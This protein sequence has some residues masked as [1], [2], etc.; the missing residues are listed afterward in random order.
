MNI[1]EWKEKLKQNWECK[2]DELKQ[3][4]EKHGNE[5][6]LPHGVLRNWLGYQKLDYRNMI[7]GKRSQM[8]LLKVQRF[9]ALG[10]RIEESKRIVTYSWKKRKQQLQEYRTTHGHL[11]I[12]LSHELLGNY[13]HMQRWGYTQFMEGKSKCN[14][15]NDARIK[16]LT[17]MGFQ[18]NLEKRKGPQDR[19]KFKSWSERFQDLLEFRRTYG[20]TRVPYE[21]Q[22]DLMLADWV[23]NQRRDYKKMKDGNKT[24]MTPEK[25]LKLFD[26]DFVFNN[27]CGRGKTMDLDKT[28][29]TAANKK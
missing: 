13:I 14:G 27:T 8:T 29:E 15:I 9:A 11:K 19:T 26:I 10:V 24:Q 2:Y 18:W 7:A 3:F 5:A 6:M 12:P 22:P 23:R 20:H 25:A 21:Y 16:I 17:D 1:G 4:K 28:V